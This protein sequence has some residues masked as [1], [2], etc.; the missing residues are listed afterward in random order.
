M[1]SA[2]PLK[3]LFLSTSNSARSI[4]AE[5]LLRHLAPQRFEVYSAGVEPQASVHPRVLEVLR[6]TYKVEPEGASSKSWEAYQGVHFDFVITVCDNA[7]E[8]CPVWPGQ[9]VIA[10]WGMADPSEETGTDEEELRAFQNTARE[11]HRRLELLLN[12]PLEKLDRLRQAEETEAIGRNQ[13]SPEA[14]EK[15]VWH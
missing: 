8:T 5:F 6:S 1:D 11:I 13:E 10:H 4:F 3:V 12:V 2:P 14:A 9:P 15:R 7:K